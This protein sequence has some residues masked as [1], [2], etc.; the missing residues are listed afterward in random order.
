VGCRTQDEQAN[1]TNRKR[2]CKDTQLWRVGGAKKGELCGWVGAEM[3][4]WQGLARVKW[5]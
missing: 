1:K 3:G 2:A 5:Q 4:A